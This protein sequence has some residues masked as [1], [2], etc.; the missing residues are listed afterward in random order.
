MAISINQQP[1]TWILAGNEAKYRVG[2]SQYLNGGNARADYKIICKLYRIDIVAGSPQAAVLIGTFNGIPSI[3]K[4][5]VVSSTTYYYA[6]FN[7]ALAIL[8]DLQ[9]PALSNTIGRT[10]DDFFR[11]YKCDFYEYYDATPGTIVSSNVCTGLAVGQPILRNYSASTF[12][13]QYLTAGAGQKFLNT[14][15]P[16]GRI[17]FDK[18][19][20]LNYYNTYAS[21][22]VNLKATAYYRNDVDAATGTWFIYSAANPGVNFLHWQILLSSVSWATSIGDPF[23]GASLTLP[24]TTEGIYKIVFEVTNPSTSVSEQLTFD[25]VHP[26]VE[27]YARVFHYKNSFGFMECLV[28]TGKRTSNDKLS[29]LDADLFVDNSATGTTKVISGNLTKYNHKLSK[30]LTQPVG[31]VD[32][33][34]YEAFKDF[35]RSERKY[36]K[37]GE[38]YYPIVLTQTDFEGMADEQTTF[39]RSFTYQYASYEGF[40]EL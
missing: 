25:I 38:Y 29:T 23:Y 1:A 31:W 16:K 19:L 27:P 36:E 28:T 24:F 14:L 30:E 8:A 26:S 4:T 17:V 33:I 21:G 3:A 6:D 5:F 15:R 34:S 9:E 40:I 37:I 2:G 10:S 39:G 11:T 7:M 18:I 35:L 13:A 32:P 12:I 22:F 20:R